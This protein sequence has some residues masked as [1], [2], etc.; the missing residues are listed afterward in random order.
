MDRTVDRNPTMSSQ[1]KKRD[2]TERVW[3][4]K[5]TRRGTTPKSKKVKLVRSEGT[6]CLFVEVKSEISCLRGAPL[7]NEDGDE[8]EN[9][10]GGPLSQA[11]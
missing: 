11:P 4:I 1:K 8:G 2:G 3:K 10:V 5:K 9:Y 7:S 6:G